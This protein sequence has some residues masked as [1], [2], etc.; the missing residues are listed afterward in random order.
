MKKNIEYLGKKILIKYMEGE[1][2]YTNRTGIVTHVDDLGQ[3]HGTWG[4]LAAIPNHDLIEIL[5]DEGNN[6][7]E[8]KPM[9]NNVTSNTTFTPEEQEMKAKFERIFGSIHNGSFFSIT[10]KTSKV[11]LKQYRA[12]MSTDIVTKTIT[13]QFRM[14]VDRQKTKRYLAKTQKPMSEASAKAQET[15]RE[16]EVWLVPNKLKHNTKTDNYLVVLSPFNTKSYKATYSRN[17]HPIGKD[18]Y[19]TLI[20]AKPSNGEV[21]DYLTISMKNIVAV[22]GKEVK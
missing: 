1:P 8:D 7:K 20:N 16:N 4:G 6:K 3:L 22:N 15:K 2:R 10:Y 19:D 9:K 11:P 12:L 13:T 5:P 21:L 17:G 14:G 18:T